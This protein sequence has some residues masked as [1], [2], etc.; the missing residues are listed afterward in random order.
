VAAAVIPWWNRPGAIP[1]VESVTQLTN[2][3]AKK[4]GGG[5]LVTDGARVYFMEDSGSGWELMQVSTAG[6]DAIRVNTKLSKVRI[7]DIAPD[8]S[9]LLLFVGGSYPAPVWLQPLPAGEPTRIGALEATAA[10]FFPDGQQISYATNDKGYIA[11]KDGSNSRQIFELKDTYIGRTRVSPNGSTIALYASKLGSESHSIWEVGV[12]G[13]HSRE[14]LKGWHDPPSE[15]QANWTPDGRYLVFVSPSW[16]VSDIWAVAKGEH[17]IGRA[18]FQPI[19]LTNGPL[20][21]SA[22]VPSRD[23]RRIFVVGS[24][25]RGELVRYDEKFRQFVPY[26]GGISATDVD[27]S[28][29][30]E[31]VTYLSYPDH[32]L[33]RMRKDGSEKLRLISS[34]LLAAEAKWSPDARKIAFGGLVLGKNDEIAVW[35]ISADGGTPEKIVDNALAPSWSPDGNSLVFQQGVPQS[36]TDIRIIDLR[37]RNISIIPDSHGKVGPLW[38]PDGRFLLAA[39]PYWGGD[40]LLF[41]FRARSWSLLAKGN[42]VNWQWS[43]DGKYVLA[44]DDN[45]GKRRAVRVGIGVKRVEAITTLE[46]IR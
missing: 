16:G 2:D 37:T 42:F 32:A 31:W 17:V 6:G 43:L 19:R 18:G 44:V 21:Y 45:P 7:T 30:G 1:I 14:V 28:R 41:D 36:K 38:S 33:W 26:L 34:G 24:K 13:T 11:D 15:W 40:L 8:A 10:S 4:D 29:D 46:N 35:T 9:A 23:G 5:P 27:F 3:G 22:P 39:T 25:L 12:D 20:S